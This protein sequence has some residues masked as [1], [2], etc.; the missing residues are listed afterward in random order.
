MQNQ[1]KYNS[2][3]KSLFYT[4]KPRHIAGRRED[5]INMYFM[6]LKTTVAHLL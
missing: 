6:L 3:E 4:I 2:F 5:T 1:I